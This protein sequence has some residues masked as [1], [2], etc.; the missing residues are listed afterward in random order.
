MKNQAYDVISSLVKDNIEKGK[1]KT[2]IIDGNI[3][4]G[5]SCILRKLK[6]EHGNSIRIYE[7]DLVY[8]DKE[9]NDYYHENSSN[10]A[11]NL[12]LKVLKHY[13]K[14]TDQ[15]LNINDDKVVVIER[16]PHTSYWVFT[17]NSKFLNEH[18]HNEIRDEYSTFHT[19][20]GYYDSECVYIILKTS[21]TR[22]LMDRICGRDKIKGDDLITNSYLEHLEKQHLVLQDFLKNVLGAKSII[23]NND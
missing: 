2:Y 16:S 23:L 20:D 7:E 11:K 3:G 1:K 22:I 12:Q 15:E 19:K 10:S 17:K 13:Y 14:L 18:H 8:I 4:S 21:S 5:K 6:K 9:L